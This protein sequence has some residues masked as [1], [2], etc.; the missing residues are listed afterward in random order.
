MFVPK[1][2]FS[3]EEVFECDNDEEVSPVSFGQHDDISRGRLFENL[4]I[5]SS[6]SA[7][8]VSN[9]G[10]TYFSKPYKCVGMAMAEDLDLDLG[11][12]NDLEL[13]C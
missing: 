2:K 3:D 11:R 6:G 8:K 1:G 9:P 5:L 13:Q 7:V 12:E 4:S 10:E